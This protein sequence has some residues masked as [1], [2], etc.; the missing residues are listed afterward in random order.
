MLDR[1]ALLVED[2]P[3]TREVLAQ[4]LRDEGWTVEAVGTGTA[5]LAAAQAARPSLVVTDAVLPGL[6]GASLCA[7]LRLDVFGDTVRV[8][9]VTAHAEAREAMLA[10][11]A[12]AFLQKPADRGSFLQ[13]AQSLYEAA[14][15]PY[16][17]DAAEAPVRVPSEIGSTAEDLR[18]EPGWLPGLLRRLHTEGF[19]GVLEVDAE[20][21]R[22]KV[23][24]H[25]GAPA[26]ARSHDE[27]TGLGRVLAEL[28]LVEASLVDESVAE[29]RRTA[30]PL[31]EVLVE[32]GLIEQSSAE[33][34]L[35]EQVVRRLC[36]AGR[37]SSGSARL[38]RAQAVGLAG[39]DAHPAAV[40]W[41]LGAWE[42]ALDPASDHALY[43]EFQPPGGLWQLLDPDGA[44]SPLRAALTGGALAGECIRAGG[45]PVA[46]LIAHLRAWGLLAL[47]ADPP[48][49]A[50][51]QAG[52]A[53]LEVDDLEAELAT[54]HRTLTDANHYTVLA[55][56]PHASAEDIQA[57]TL[58][59]L[60]RWRPENLPAGVDPTGRGR[61]RALY[62][63]ALEAGRVLGD[64]RRRAIY[65]SVLR[66]IAVTTLARV[67]TEDHAVLQADRARDLF[68]KG[69]FVLASALFR[70]ALD[71]E[72]ESAAIL[73][74]LGWAR[75]RACPEGADAGEAELRRAIEL[76]AEDEFTWY[77]LGRLLM[78]R[79]DAQEASVALRRAL[80]L[81]PEFTPARDALREA[82]RE[83]A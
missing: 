15:P 31:A 81:N 26:A 34:A 28:G 40:T 14:E 42:G 22:V 71:L 18:V 82:P 62:E 65:D 39:F 60:A 1:R 75:H 12:D 56:D 27:R 74:M 70:I 7:R 72:G 19:T 41:R 80:A 64:P 29:G 69:E 4:W 46:R 16:R 30:R 57:A 73:S 54:R 49:A 17:R 44:L 33:R 76:D 24:F 45:E 77:Y 43:V 78:A 47:V 36:D 63:R 3:V 61:A 25:R 83:D 2:D 55:L 59:A 53:E 51:A 23:Y 50:R 8:L 5:A 48:P 10:A 58:T 11:G 13:L 52:L 9:V 6:D 79:G 20:P 38:T 21:S 68:R 32:R 67:G 66:R 35:R 37:G